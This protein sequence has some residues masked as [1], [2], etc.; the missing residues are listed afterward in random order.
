MT[1]RRSRKHG[2]NDDADRVVDDDD[3]NDGS[4]KA[5]SPSD[6]NALVQRP[7][8]SLPK[9][10]LAVQPL[11]IALR[12]LCYDRHQTGEKEVP[13]PRY[14]IFYQDWPKARQ[15][16]RSTPSWTY[17]V[18][19]SQYSADLAFIALN[20]TYPTPIDVYTYLGLVGRSVK[21]NADATDDF[22]ASKVTGDEVL[23][24]VDRL[25]RLWEN[26]EGGPFVD[27]RL[28]EEAEAEGLRLPWAHLKPSSAQRRRSN[29]N[30]DP[31]KL[32]EREAFNV[33]PPHEATGQ[34]ATMTDQPQRSDIWTRAPELMITN[35]RAL[36]PL[37]LS[38]LFLDAGIND[39]K[40]YN[41]LIATLYHPSV[42]IYNVALEPGVYPSRL[43]A[44]VTARFLRYYE[45]NYNT[46]RVKFLSQFRDPSSSATTAARPPVCRRWSN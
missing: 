16:V 33:M 35:V 3:R 37:E 43:C 19:N 22:Y 2:L 24:G 44:E 32:D 41:A 42:H 9:S 8:S 45:G 13:P 18:D 36:A 1:R 10:K 25:S 27:P 6:M 7:I 40:T 34:D 15:W 29:R 38:K 12:F 21:R 20:L 4:H 5:N 30:K 46:P 31:S 26:R 28:C 17:L 39:A 11:A 14:W 23:I